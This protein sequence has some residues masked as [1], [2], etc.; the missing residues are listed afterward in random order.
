MSLREILAALLLLAQLAGC[1]VDRPLVQA[2]AAVHA[3]P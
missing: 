2:P 1:D 3:A